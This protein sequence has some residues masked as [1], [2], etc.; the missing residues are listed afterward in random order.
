MFAEIWRRH[1]SLNEAPFAH[2]DAD[3]DPV[4]A[5]LDAFAVH[6]CFD[7]IFGD[8]E[9]PGPGVVFGEKGSGKSGLRLA[10][11]R[12]LEDYNEAHPEARVFSIVYS[13]F[14]VFL[15]R[16]RQAEN[17]APG[18][19]TT[20]PKLIERFDMADHLDAILSMGVTQ[21][22][23]GLVEDKAQARQLDKKHKA[24]LLSLVG[25]YYRSNDRT[26]VEA[27]RKLRSAMRYKSVRPPLLDV[28]KAVL[29]IAAIGIALVPHYDTL[30]IVVSDDW[31]PGSPKIWYGAAGALLAFTWIWSFVGRMMLKASATKATRSVRVVPRDQKQLAKIVAQMSPSARRELAL[32]TEHGEASRYLLLERFLGVLRDLDYNSFYVLVDRVDEATLLGG[33]EAWMQPFI[34]CLLEHKLLQFDGL[35][36]KLFL[37][38]ELS[39]LYLGASPDDLKRM[40]LD[41][42][43]TVSEL[44]WMGQELFEAA[45]QR[46]R[47]VRGASGKPGADLADYFD[48]SVDPADVRD[49]LHE[50][51]TPRHA[52][53]FLG[54]LFTEYARNLPE[55]LDD[56]SDDWRV[57]RSQF[58]IVR[59]SWAD[60]ARVMR[61]TMN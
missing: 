48:P 31:S 47:A 21:L 26:R 15:D 56:D 29:S 14:D 10:V 27:T 12:R 1:W 33:K 55:Q 20:T 7:R 6:S 38:I 44:R 11:E 3:K 5:K 25:L 45:N 50:L 52:F 39:K 2:E 43:N 4:L 18:K 17:I 53:G 8:P 28:L 37:P 13:D 60:R 61:R 16:V 22:V 58:E 23:D 41:K 40:R 54:T 34:E 19:P 59:A 36:L 46:L 42:A 24:D 35:A 30:G 49:A 32:P 51:G 57:S 9:A